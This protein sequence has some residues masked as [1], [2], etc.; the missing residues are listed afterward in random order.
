MI[1]KEKLMLKKLPNGYGSIKY[2]GK[3]RRNPYVVYP[4][5][6]EYYPNG[7]MKSPKALCYVPN[8]MIAMAVLI[9]YN[10]GTY[11]PGDELKMAGQEI[12]KK[13]EPKVLDALQRLIGI[14]ASAKFAL[15]SAVTF[16]EMFREVYQKKFGI[17]V[18]DKP[19]NSNTTLWKLA[20]N[21]LKPLHHKAMASIKQEEVKT[22]L[23]SLNLSYSYSTIVS[24]SVKA[25]YREAEAKG[26]I[27]KNHMTTFQYKPQREAV[28]GVPFSDE[29]L[30][31]LWQHENER[32]ARLYLIMCYSGFRSAAYESLEINLDD[33]YFKGGVKN[34]ASKNRIVPI[35]TCIRHLVLKEL[36][37]NGY[38]M[39]KQLKTAR[40][41]E[42][43]KSLGIREHTP[44]DARHTFSYLCEKFGVKEND[45]KR[46][47]G[48][49]FNDM[50]NSV[51][52]HRTLEQ[53][54]SEIEKIRP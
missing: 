29:E 39:I 19:Y 48:H 27:A 9:A 38:I 21:K 28:S 7:Y 14:D 25:V 18:D 45:R 41:K 4:P 17:S 36:E 34:K 13:L 24:I 33:W 8:R 37:E 30:T 10:N 51:Y 11:R 42:F 31:T 46:L 1:R 40:A 54:R 47:L 22:L 2:L 3:G 53:L 50:T 32:I 44:H 6:T 43:L 12:D 26:A 23:D 20:Y 52:G 5:A 16:G 49:A 15:T 35:H